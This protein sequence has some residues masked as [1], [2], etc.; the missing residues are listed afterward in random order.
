MPM[1]G[2]PAAELMHIVTSFLGLSAVADDNSVV[3]FEPHVDNVRF[4]AQHEQE[5]TLR[6][7]K[8]RWRA[9]A[10]TY[11][12][13]LHSDN[14]DT[15]TIDT[16][17]E[18]MG[19]EYD[20]TAGTY[21]RSEKWQSHLRAARDSFADP[22]L[23]TVHDFVSA[24]STIAHYARI[25]RYEFWR[26]YHPMRFARSV[27]K[28]ISLNNTTMSSALKV[29]PSVAN[30]MIDWAEE[31]LPN[32]WLPC[33]QPTHADREV[34][35]FTDASITGYGTVVYDGAQTFVMG[36]RWTKVY[37]PSDISWLAVFAIT[38]GV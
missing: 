7:V 19:L 8:T 38:K 14:P 33:Q 3:T 1:G 2:S 37:K 22:A 25:S 9:L 34:Y 20:Y 30:A 6:R 23:M 17:N 31:L 26:R 24:Y 10:K 29:W 5:E 12:V 13:T 36:R 32:P 27:A 28:T 16:Q 21:R 18:F 15:D 35:V 11:H 4:V